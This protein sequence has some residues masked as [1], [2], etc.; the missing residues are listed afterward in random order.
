VKVSGQLHTLGC[1]TP[2]E[3]T[4]ANPLNRRLGGPQSF[5]RDA[6]PIPLPGTEL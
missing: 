2:D 5:E 3:G 6:N 1:F 4:L